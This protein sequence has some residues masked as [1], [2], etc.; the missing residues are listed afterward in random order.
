MGKKVPSGYIWTGEIHISDRAFPVHLM[1]QCI[2]K[3]MFMN[4]LIGQMTW[5]IWPF[6]DCI[7]PKDQ[8][9]HVMAQMF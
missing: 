2:L 9:S 1:N 7:C 4:T 5:L 8:V 3:I 6:T